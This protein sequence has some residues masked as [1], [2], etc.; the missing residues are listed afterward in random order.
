MF[1]QNGQGLN[2]LMF[3]TILDQN[4]RNI[5][6]RVHAKSTE[7]RGSQPMSEKLYWCCRMPANDSDLNDDTI[8]CDTAKCPNLGY[9]STSHVS[10]LN[11]HPKSADFVH[12]AGKHQ[13][14]A[15]V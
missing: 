7:S 13:N 14:R 3:H 6:D 8:G 15:M 1:P 12:C 2:G 11:E 4:P 9:G 5:Y 10:M